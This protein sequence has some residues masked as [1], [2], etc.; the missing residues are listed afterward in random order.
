MRRSSP[1]DSRGNWPDRV[2]FFMIDNAT[3]L[4]LVLDQLYQTVLAASEEQAP[5]IRLLRDLHG[6]RDLTRPI[7]GRMPGAM[8]HSPSSGA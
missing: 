5:G 4:A 7:P 6:R 2:L 3:T 8:D 1:E